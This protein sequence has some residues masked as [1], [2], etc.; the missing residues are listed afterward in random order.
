M[1]A[2]CRQAACL[3]LLIL[4]CVLTLSAQQTSATLLGTVVDT[5]G[6]SIPNVTIRVVNLGT[7][8][9]REAVTDPAGNYSLT[10]LP[11]G[12]YHLTA[13]HEGF[14]AQ[15]IESV[16]LQVDQ[17]ARMDFT[18]KVGNVSDTVE[19]SAS[20]AVL[21]TENASVGTVI[22][23]AKIVELPLNGRNFIQ[24]AQLIP[25]VQAGTPGSITVRRG[26][27]SVGQTDAAYGSTAASANGSRDTANRFF[28][29]G[30]EVM[31]YDAMTYSFSP[32]VDSLA[33]FKVQTSTYSGEY[34][35]APGGQVNMLTK[36]GS[37]HLHFTLW[38][39]NRN[40]QL[41]QSYDAIAGKSVTSPRLNRNQFGANI[42]GPVLFPKLY[43]GKDKTFFFFNWESGYAAQGASPVYKTVPTLAQRNGDFTGLQDART[44]LPLALKDPLNI[45]IVGNMIPKSALSPQTQAF[46]NFEPTPNTSNGVFNYLTTAASAVSTQRNFTGRVD[47]NLS[48]KDQISGRYV[49][50]DTYEAQIPIWGHDERN[51]LGRTQNVAVSWT[52]IFR[53]TLVNEARG[54]WHRFNEA[55][56]FG[57]TNDPAFDVVGK[58][59]LPLVS[60]LPE[61]YGPPSISVSGPDGVYNMYDLQRQIGPRV[62]SNSISPFTDTLSWQKDRHFLKF[63][64]EVDY[65]GVTFGQ[66][67]AP[68]A[69]FSFDGTYTG[70]AAAD[71]ILGYIRSDNV[72]PTHT[73]TDLYDYWYA[74]FVNDDWK[75]TPRLT[76]TLGL[77]YDYFQRYKQKDD[78]FVNIELNGFVLGKTVTP[79]TSQ[80][81]RELLAPDRNNFGPRFGF[82][83]RPPI[84]GETVIRGGYGI[85]YTPQISNAIFAMAEGAQ[86]TAGATITGNIVGAPNV[87][88]SNPFP[89]AQTSAGLP[90]AVSNDQNM[91]D[92]Y[93][94]QWNFDIQRKIP[95]NIVLDVGY[96]GSK[97]TR[98]IVTYDDL[99][100]PLQVVDP[101][102]PGLASLN[103]RRPDQEYLRAVRA[104]KSVGNSIYHALQVKAEK[105]MSSGLTFLTA[106]T[107]S[108]SISGPSD[109]GGQVGGGNFI[110]APQDAYYMQGDRAVSGFDVTQR[111]VQTVLYDI[112]FARGLHGA[113]KYLLDGWQVSTIMTFQSGFPAP[114]TFGVDTTGTGIG[115]RPDLVPGQN[116]NLPGDQRT[117]KRWFNTGA[118]MQTPFGRF[119]TA[120]RTDAIRLPG[121]ATVDFSINKKL[122][123]KE[124]RS[125]EF[126]TEFFNLFN[127]FNPD[128]ATVDLNIR[129]ATFG[130]VG[131]GVQGITT[132]V[133]QLGAKLN[134]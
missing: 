71:F 23:S 51:N 134:F 98:L 12:N 69:S 10:Y 77:R 67:R 57:T 26:R 65:R 102:T 125:L 2:L 5:S 91:R 126:R 132:R 114:I 42:G 70:S 1:F 21:Q 53:P 128:P 9:K 121:I 78:R 31:D 40:D 58:M 27:G 87:F 83:W 82:A 8:I 47:H 62:R 43:H 56:V 130:A 24:L 108:K 54:G 86:A 107:Y 16:T 55:E 118:F 73:N 30:I 50:N 68:R 37:N 94:Q 46:L 81:G 29:D 6:A 96:V 25:G 48:S 124:T 34:G 101:R 123:I 100:R 104:D 115:S 112:P 95:A 38:E 99:N 66:A 119:G 36:S 39:F 41:T 127:N 22:D 89:A 105:R 93:V 60:R 20:A 106:Y 7:N 44:H 4:L 28:L 14:Q 19:V 18:L 109:I 72:N 3:A 15:Q 35:G 129:S 133:I 61:E 131:G 13:Q 11:A 122:R 111:F 85:Y 32:S 76:L 52:R 113:P 120:P 49:F 79:T 64:A 116:G 88:F 74:F 117:W 63:G 110:G 59:G 97:G 75:A 92:S 17:T 80:Y 84:S 90:F 45:G 103:A 33:E